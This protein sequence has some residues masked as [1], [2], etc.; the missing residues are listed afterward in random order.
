[1]E[2]EQRKLEVKYDAVLQNVFQKRKQKIE[3]AKSYPDFWLRVLA[4][5]TVTKDFINEADKSV[6]KYLKDI[7]YSK[8]E[9]DNVNFL[10]FY[11]NFYLILFFN[12]TYIIDLFY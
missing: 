1:M 7:S 4:N 8:T 11:F 2:D 12:K 9:N 5:H 3:E 10:F 6:L